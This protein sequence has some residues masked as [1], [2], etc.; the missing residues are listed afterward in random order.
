LRPELQLF[1]IVTQKAA[2]AAISPS[3]KRAMRTNFKN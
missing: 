1:V 2:A 3:V